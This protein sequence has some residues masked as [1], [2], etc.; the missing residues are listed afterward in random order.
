MLMA[1]RL[2]GDRAAEH[3][4]RILDPTQNNPEATH[5]IHAQNIVVR[6]KHNFVNFLLQDTKF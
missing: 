5:K 6:T 4:I 1:M 3:F 2:A